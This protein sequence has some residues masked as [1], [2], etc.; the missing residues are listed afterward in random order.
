MILHLVR[1]WFTEV[2]TIGELFVDGQWECYTLEDAVREGP[3]IPGKTA[4]PEGTYG[5]IITPSVRFKKDMPLICD[6]PEFSGV[7]IHSGNTS[8]DTE[9]CILVGQTRGEDCIGRSRMAFDLL[10]AKM[11]VGI[12]AR[13]SIVLTVSSEEA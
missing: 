12:G 4:I 13:M 7:R 1:K 5:V 8:E 11:K 2:S 10:F 3:K 6:V 9:G